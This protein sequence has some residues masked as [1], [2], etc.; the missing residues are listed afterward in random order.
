M[1][2]LCP[3]QPERWSCWKLFWGILPKEWICW[4][5]QQFTFASFEFEMLHAFSPLRNPS[6]EI[7]I[8]QAD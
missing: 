4:D 5:H 7:W 1:L 8:C 2:E 3:E 6:G